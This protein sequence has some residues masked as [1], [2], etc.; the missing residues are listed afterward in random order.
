MIILD[1]FLFYFRREK[2]IQSLIQSYDVYE[3][4]LAKTQK[5]IDYYHRLDASIQ[6]LLERARRVCSAQE[7]ERLAIISRHQPKGRPMQLSL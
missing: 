1:F 5:G 2:K 3:D 4:L 7:E 6:Q